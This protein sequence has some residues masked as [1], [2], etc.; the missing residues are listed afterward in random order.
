M[1]GVDMNNLPHER[2]ITYQMIKY[3]RLCRNMTQT[4]FGEIC[5]INQGVLAQI[6]RGDIELSIHYASK[7]MDGCKVLN[8]SDLELQ[9]IQNLLQLKQNRESN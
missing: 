1:I 9:S 7:I 5:K 4:Q 2:K 6:E 3:I 8:I